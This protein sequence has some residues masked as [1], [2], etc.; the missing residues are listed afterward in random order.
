MTSTATLSFGSYDWICSR[1]ALIVCPL[2]GAT[3]YG[4]EPVCYSRNVEFG[5]T[6]V[7][8][9]ATSFM[10]ICAL[11][12]VVIM[13]LHV[14]SKY[15]AVGRKEILIFFYIYFLEELL[16]IFLDSGIIPPSSN[17]YA[18]F[19]A[20]HTGL[21]AAT[22]WC[23]LVNGFVG[24][25]MV[26]DGTPLSL[27]TL[28]GT[29]AIVGLIVGLVAI[30]TFKNS[31]GL[32]SAKPTGLWILQFIFPLACV[33]VYIVA[34]FFLVLRTLDD[35]WPIGDILFGTAFWVI[36]QVLLFAFSNT[37]CDAVSHYLDG[38]FFHA[39][40]NLFAVMMTYKYWDSLTKEDLEFSVSSKEKAWE[41]KETLL[42]EDDD[43]S[44]SGSG[45]GGGAGYGQGVYPPQKGGYGQYG[46]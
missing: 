21:T 34:Q 3:H 28:Q 16:A 5:R 46:Y 14:R 35:R 27:W 15:T 32:S 18:W 43:D 8:Q 40:C 44:P 6:L 39:L 10:H 42:R 29:S 9:P 38:T 13:I 22:Y 37:I 26:E 24:F 2:L 33:V 17:V 25:Q 30:G 23:L 20:V 12:M 4:I 41:V 11:A 36:A 19:A 7:F 45:Y 31:A 1:A